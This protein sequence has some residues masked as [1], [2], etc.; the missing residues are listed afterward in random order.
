MRRLG[1]IAGMVRETG[2]LGAPDPGRYRA[3]AVG[4]SA[5]R[6]YGIAKDWADRGE[7]SALLSFGIA[8]GLDP[9]LRPGDLL[10]A[11][12]V[13]GASGRRFAVDA[14]WS[15][16]MAARLP[17][18]RRGAVLGV[19]AEAA[20]AADK[21]RHFART[22]AV[23]CD[24]ES[25]GV[26]HAAQDAALPFAALRAVA[27]PADRALPTVVL[28][29]LTAAGKPRLGALFA[30]LLRAPAQLPALMQVGRDA[31]AA[32]AALLFAVDR[33]GDALAAP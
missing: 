25:E 21:R 20:T 7:V 29:L 17:G 23:A 13:I 31:R 6:A 27:D 19:E 1:I 22:G 14:A 10:V 11:T 32:E 16:A 28:G 26:A 15:D 5:A 12:G 2:C 24:M 18:C 33:L 8:G 4:G 9:A 3:A 30:R